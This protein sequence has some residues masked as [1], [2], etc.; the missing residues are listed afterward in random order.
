M[1]WFK[2]QRKAIAP[3]GDKSVRVPEGLW[4][5]CAGCNE[6]IYNKDLTANLNVCPRCTHHFRLG[7]VDRLRSLFDGKWQEFDR[8]LRSTDPLGFV[9][10]KPY[11]ERL[12]ASQQA[13]GL[14][15]AIICAAGSLD[16]IGVIIAAMEYGFIGGSM[17][18]VVGEKL[19]RAIERALEGL[20]PL[21]VV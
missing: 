10:T 13:T 7:A 17:G 21:V 14:S 6:I 16:G 1:A 12:A 18:V 15:D 8:D 19:T 20:V 2:R 4:V 9:D 3:A 5:K 11:K